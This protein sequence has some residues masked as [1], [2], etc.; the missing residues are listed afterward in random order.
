MERVAVSFPARAMA[1]PCVRQRLV[2]TRCVV[3]A[4]LQIGRFT[5]AE[6][7]EIDRSAE[8]LIAKAMSLG[9]SCPESPQATQSHF[10]FGLVVPKAAAKSVCDAAT[11]LGVKT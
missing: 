11:Q 8:P 7:A 10:P 6:S 2:P 4:P 5:A 9:G 3:G 1:G